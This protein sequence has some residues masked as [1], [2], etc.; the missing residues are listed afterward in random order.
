VSV[1]RALWDAIGIAKAGFRERFGAQFGSKV[2]DIHAAPFALR[3]CKSKWGS[4]LGHLAQNL[5]G[6]LTIIFMEA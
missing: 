5:S 1:Q 4:V 3:R 2:N 6:Y